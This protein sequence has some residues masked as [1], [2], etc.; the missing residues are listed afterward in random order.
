MSL[1]S[2]VLSL[3]LCC[4]IVPCPINI[5]LVVIGS[6]LWVLSNKELFWR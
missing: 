1:S 6:V 4:I 5:V 3:A 2:L